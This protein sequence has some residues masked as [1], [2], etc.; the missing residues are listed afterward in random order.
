LISNGARTSARISDGRFVAV[1][2]AMTLRRGN[3]RWSAR[4]QCIWNQDV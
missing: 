2:N 1:L 3:H 4:N